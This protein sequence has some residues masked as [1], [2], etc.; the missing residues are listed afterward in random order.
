VQSSN[1]T[2]SKEETGLRRCR[3][4]DIIL[5]WDPSQ[6]SEPIIKAIN[7]QGVAPE[8]FKDLEKDPNYVKVGFVLKMIK[9]TGLHSSSRSSGNGERFV[10]CLLRPETSTLLPYR[11]YLKGEGRFWWYWTNGVSVLETRISRRAN[12]VSVLLETY[13]THLS[14]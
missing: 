14:V 7:S 1:A 10:A 9:C 11:E 13:S 5:E 6:G 12:S 2:T 4:K 8:L 3:L